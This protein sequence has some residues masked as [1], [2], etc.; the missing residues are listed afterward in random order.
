[1]KLFLLASAIPSLVSGFGDFGRDYSKLNPCFNPDTFNPDGTWHNHCEGDNYFSRTQCGL[2][3][4]LW[5]VRAG[6]E[7]EFPTEVSDDCCHCQ[8]EALCASSGSYVTASVGEYLHSEAV[9][10]SSC[11]VDSIP[12]LDC[13]EPDYGSPLYECLGGTDESWEAFYDSGDGKLLFDVV[14]AGRRF[15]E[16][17]DAGQAYPYW[18]TLTCTMPM[19]QQWSHFYDAVMEGQT[20]ICDEYAVNGWSHA[21]C[22]DSKPK[23]GSDRTDW[24][25]CPGVVEFLGDHDWG[26]IPTE[27]QVASYMMC[28]DWGTAACRDDIVAQ[29]G[30]TG[31]S[32]QFFNSL[33]ASTAGSGGD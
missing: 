14:E 5:Q 1:M 10:P 13:D 28:D 25:K 17:D 15:C 8:T 31:S 18:Q 6:C 3:G 32:A 19:E 22:T 30:E 20:E 23:C 11:D 9:L 27:E 21:C 12:F 4:C 29:E 7:G 33:C 26:T 16:V 24:S 2:A